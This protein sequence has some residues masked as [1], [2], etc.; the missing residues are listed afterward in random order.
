MIHSQDLDRFLIVLLVTTLAVAFFTQPGHGA[1]TP[2]AIIKA[3]ADKTVSTLRDTNLNRDGN[4][5]PLR[6]KLLSQ[7][8]PIID[9]KLMTRSA[10]GPAA[11]SVNQDQLKELTSVFRPLVVRLYTDRLLE[12]M[13]LKDPPWVLD[14][15]VVKDQEIRGGGSYAMV[16][17]T[18]QVHRGDNEREL[19]MDFKMYKQKNRWVVYDI[20][21]EGVSMV[22]NYRS[23]FSSVLANNSVETLTEKLR[24]N[25][26][27]LR[28]ESLED[29]VD[30]GTESP[31]KATD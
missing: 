20:V 19:S 8:K 27:K 21:F 23:Q 18:A 6:D 17:S 2:S 9:F 4:F 3:Y 26:E 1:E 15:I 29:R 7:L 10:L 11:R 5:N 12:Y 28:S 25:L 14:K 16:R 13:A 24:D 31:D 30:T 22:E